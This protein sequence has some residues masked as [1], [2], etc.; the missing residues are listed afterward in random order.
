MVINRMPVEE[1]LPGEHRAITLMIA[2][3]QD[4]IRERYAGK[5]ALRDAHPKHHGLVTATFSVDRECPAE[6]R[7]G[8]FSTPGRYAAVIRYSNGHPEVDHDLASDIRG[9]ALHVSTPNASLLGDMA[10][11]F[12]LS[13]GEA[14]FGTNA[15]DYVDFPAASVSP[16]KVLRYF[17][18]GRRWR[19]GWQLIKGRTNPASPLVADYF[20]QTPY[21]LGPH[22][23]KYQVR[24][25]ATVPSNRP[26]YLKRRV[27]FVLGW[28]VFVAG[29]FRGREAVRG[30]P[31]FNALRDSLARDLAHGSVTL[32][33]LVQRWPDLS[34]LPV[35]AI[36]DATRV[37]NAPWIKVATI[38]V[39]QQ[40]DIPSR[41]RQ[42]EQMNV[43]PWRAYPEHQPLGSINRARLAIYREMSAFRT[44][45]NGG[46]P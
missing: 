34:T 36:E 31:E 7:H 14:F 33:F 3:L 37:W 44:R 38:E 32:E 18:G 8:V 30:I 29:L 23:V 21:R 2:T 35:W 12:V 1:M 9:M 5:T 28:R 4:Q 26:W 6:L 27:R 43:S 25:A 16:P 13:T 24:P 19:G 39:H 15:V 10:Q 46:S 45:L 41:D 17:I 20:S 11:D 40:A 22:C 42:A